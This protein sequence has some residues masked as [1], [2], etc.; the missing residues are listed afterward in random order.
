[1]ALGVGVGD[2][3]LSVFFV[4]FFFD[5][6]GDADSSAVAVV[7]FFIDVFLVDAF[8]V[9]AA[10]EVPADVVDVSCFCAQETIKAVPITATIKGK[11]NFF[12]GM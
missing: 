3:S 8:L 2:V 11:N 4:D 12:I 10:V 6:L 9:V 1:M 7:L 5:S